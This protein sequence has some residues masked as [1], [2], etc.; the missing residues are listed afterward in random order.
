LEKQRLLTEGATHAVTSLGGEEKRQ[1]AR[2][3]KKIRNPFW[4]SDKRKRLASRRTSRLNM[5]FD[6]EQRW[7]QN[8]IEGAPG[9]EGEFRKHKLMLGWQERDPPSDDLAV[10]VKLRIRDARQVCR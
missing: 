9:K 7:K 4:T 2:G 5:C 8:R 1:N 3:R 10:L 6:L